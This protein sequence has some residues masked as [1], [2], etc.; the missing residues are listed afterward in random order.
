MKP[1]EIIEA[2]V[3]S[4]INLNEEN[5]LEEGPTLNLLP[6]FR[7]KQISN[8]KEKLPGEMPSEILDLLEYTSG[9]EISYS[10]EASYENAHNKYKFIE[11][12]QIIRFIDYE[13]NAF[14][15]INGI[16]LCND[17]ENGSCILDV[18]NNGVWGNVY[19]CNGAIFIKIAESLGEFLKS[20]FNYFSQNEKSLLHEI[21]VTKSEEIA[22][23]NLNMHD[24]EYFST[25]ND[26][27]IL[28]FKNNLSF[29]K[30]YKI[31]DLRN[32]E[33][34]SGFWLNK[35]QE[36]TTFIRLGNID[37]WA[38]EIVEKPTRK[39]LLKSISKIFGNK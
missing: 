7:E 32:S 37:L 13:K 4:G 11:L 17:L 39:G 2:T 3:E 27:D 25:K 14:G 36:E 33:I 18:N 38:M 28:K 15:F 16:S 23:D 31:I 34:G 1:K 5:W 9:I 22:N 35:D 30:K 29:D 8:L 6:K 26:S 21:L 20:V 24:F 19:F 10:N 12:F